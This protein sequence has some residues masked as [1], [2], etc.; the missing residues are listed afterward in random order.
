MM[1]C[2]TVKWM[3]VMPAV[4]ATVSLFRVRKALAILRGNSLLIRDPSTQIHQIPFLLL[5]QKL[6]K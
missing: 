4:K 3:Q 5:Q 6:P 2:W 1:V